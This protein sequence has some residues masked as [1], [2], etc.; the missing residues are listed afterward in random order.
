MYA[1]YTYNTE[2]SNHASQKIGDNM[3]TM[4][5]WK[6]PL[7]AAAVVAGY[8]AFAGAMGTLLAS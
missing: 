5:D 3:S 6:A 7:M 4:N 2:T 1:L 8:L